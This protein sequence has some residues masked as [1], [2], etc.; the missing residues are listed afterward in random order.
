MKKIRIGIVGGAGY[1]GG[2]LLRLLIHH[3]QSD[4]VY[5][6]SRSNAGK[7]ITAV[8][9]DLIGETN[10]V[11][12]G[13]L[14]SDIDLLFLCIGHGEA[15]K[16]LDENNID[17]KVRVIDLSQDFRLAGNAEYN[18]R[19]FTYGLPELNKESIKI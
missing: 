6:H 15:S 3:P 1:T 14:L 10:L 8:H 19:R 11:F 16:F 13:D 5:I 12:T 18:N 2:E 17:Q 4:I 7:P 9:A